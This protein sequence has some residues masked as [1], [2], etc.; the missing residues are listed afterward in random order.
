ML[1]C[2]FKCLTFLQILLL[3][4]YFISFF[5]F[6]L[7]DS[8]SVLNFFLSIFPHFFFLSFVFFEFFTFFFQTKFTFCPVIAACSTWFESSVFSLHEFKILSRSIYALII[9]IEYYMQTNKQTLIW[10]DRKQK[11]T[12][13]HFIKKNWSA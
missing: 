5:Y 6:T 13:L 1:I 10:F 9:Y 4:V 8:Y 12:W 11:K 7:D 3:I 2:S